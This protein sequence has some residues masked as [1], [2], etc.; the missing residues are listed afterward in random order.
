MYPFDSIRN[1]TF[2]I[3]R[4]RPFLF[5][6]VTIATVVLLL[7][8]YQSVASSSSSH[9]TTSYASSFS[10]ANAEPIVLR[11]YQND[12]HLEYRF[13]ATNN[14]KLRFSPNSLRQ[15]QQQQNL[16]SR[17]DNSILQNTNKQQQSLQMD[18]TSSSNIYPKFRL[19]HLDLK[20]APPKFSYLMNILPLLKE[21]GANGK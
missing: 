20:G 18:T 19:V 7:F 12:K 9:V 11:N 14:N 4:R 15:Q 16:P 6:F 5:A 8:Q 2:L 1:V 3:W 10:A 21:A 17:L 13:D